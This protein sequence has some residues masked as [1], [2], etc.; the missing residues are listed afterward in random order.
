MPAIV[1]VMETGEKAGKLEDLRGI[2]KKMNIY[3]LPCT[4]HYY[5][6]YTQISCNPV[7]Y[8]LFT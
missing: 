1:L 3:C 7:W 5:I 4:R 2:D 8:L 6:L